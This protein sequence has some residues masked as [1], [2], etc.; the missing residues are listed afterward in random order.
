MNSGRAY[1]IKA[2]NIPLASRTA[3]GVPIPQVLPKGAEGDVT[4]ILSVDSFNENDQLVLC[5]KQGYIKKTSIDAFA[6]MSRREL[7]VMTV[8][9]NDSL[10]WVR[11][12]EKNSDILVSTK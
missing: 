6:N 12:C 7:R 9:E 4:A 8:P 2:Y 1:K 5:S 3:K 11:K 10:L